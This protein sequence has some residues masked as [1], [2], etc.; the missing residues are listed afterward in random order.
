MANATDGDASLAQKLQRE[1]LQMAQQAPPPLPPVP[2]YAGYNVP[3]VLFCC[4]YPPA[5][6][7]DCLCLWQ[8]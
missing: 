1:E 6:H 4:I 8:I 3:Q 7:D 5:V 2:T